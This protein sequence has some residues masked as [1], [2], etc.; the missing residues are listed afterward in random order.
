M[1]YDMRGIVS[2]R[3]VCGIQVTAEAGA[4]GKK[5]PERR[6]PTVG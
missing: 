2:S 6:H 3:P 4:G 1:A 5:P